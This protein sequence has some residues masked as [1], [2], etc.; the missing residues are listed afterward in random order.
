[1]A[2]LGGVLVLLCAAQSSRHAVLKTR[3]GLIGPLPFARGGIVREPTIAVGP[4]GW[5]EPPPRIGAAMTAAT[6][7]TDRL[8]AR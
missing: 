4:G 3:N 6:E 7:V 2:A 8:S 1:L 5:E